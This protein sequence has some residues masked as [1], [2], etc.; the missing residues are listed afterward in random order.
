[1]SIRHAVSVASENAA[2]WSHGISGGTGA[3]FSAGT[4]TNSAAVPGTVLADDPEGVAERFLAVPARGA[5]A[6][7]RGRG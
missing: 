6:A 2:A 4:T 3:R 5:R 7:A 1:M